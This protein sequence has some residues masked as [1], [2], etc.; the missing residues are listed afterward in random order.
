MEAWKRE[1]EYI[2]S[3]RRKQMKK[4]RGKGTTIKIKR[5]ADTG[6]FV[7]EEYVEKHTKTTVTEIRKIPPKKK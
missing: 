6:R 3:L 7:T 4:K 5:D 2:N 1:K